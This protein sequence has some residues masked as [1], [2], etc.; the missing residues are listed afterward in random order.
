MS[1]RG[2]TEL[3]ETV[4]GTVAMN[5]SHFLLGR[6]WRYKSSELARKFISA[7]DQFSMPL[8]SH[9][10]FLYPI[11]AIPRWVRRRSKLSRY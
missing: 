6:G 10:R 11:L 3:D 2:A 1:G 4:F 8:P 7:E 9:L 5:L